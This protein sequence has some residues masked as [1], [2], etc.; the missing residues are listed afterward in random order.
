[1]IKYHGGPI[2]PLEVAHAVWKKGHGFVSFAYPDQI[3]N[4]AHL[5]ESFA[6]DGGQF[7][8]WTQGLEFD[9]AGYA[10]FVRE[11]QR[12]PGYDFHIA[13]DDILGS[14]SAQELMLAR[15]REEFGLFS[16]DGRMVPVWHFH[17]SIGRLQRLCRTYPRVALGSSGQFSEPESPSWWQRIGEAMDAICGG[18]D[19]RPP[20]KLHGLRMLSN[21]ICSALPLASADSTNIARNH[22]RYR[23][24]HSLS[25]LAAAISMRDAIEGHPVATRWSRTFGHQE[26]MELVG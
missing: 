25:P 8:A 26:N 5:C 23:K 18:E 19:G 10:A 1:M 21:T 9:M 12:H 3:G 24:T 16:L 4:V 2:T 6:L 7:T 11:W 17:E 14:E 22:A 20:C 15:W 13:P